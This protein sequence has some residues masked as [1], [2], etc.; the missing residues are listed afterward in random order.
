MKKN[1][2]SVLKGQS[3]KHGL[4]DLGSVSPIREGEVG[5]RC[6]TITCGTSCA[7]PS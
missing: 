2:F 5:K 6:G 3:L 7:C 1:K 4:L